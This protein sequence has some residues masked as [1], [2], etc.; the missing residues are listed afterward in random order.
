M[1]D[2]RDNNVGFYDNQ[3]VMESPLH[4][5]FNSGNNMND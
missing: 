4:M 1:I 3:Q 2:D 5:H